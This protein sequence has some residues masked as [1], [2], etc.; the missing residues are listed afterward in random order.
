MQM[1]LIT[2]VL[3]VGLFALLSIMPGNAVEMLITSNPRVRPEDIVRLK[4]LRGLDRPW[5]VQYHRW[6]WGYYDPYRAPHIRVIDPLSIHWNEDQTKVFVDLSASLDNPDYPVNF[7]K[8]FLQLRAERP[9]LADR[10]ENVVKGA[11]ESQK[12]TTFL[13]TIFYEDVDYYNRINRQMRTEASSNLKIEGLFG[14]LVQ[15][16]M[17]Q[18]GIGDDNFH[19]LWFKVTNIH[20]LETISSVQV[21]RPSH[22][23]P[24]SAQIIVDDIPIQIV[25]DPQ[26]FVVNL[27]QYV[28]C[29]GK[30]CQ[31]YTFGLEPGSP[32]I[33]DAQGV[34]KNNFKTPGQSEVRFSI[35]DSR[36]EISRGAFAVEHGYV[37]NK[38]KFNRGFLFIFA[39]DPLALGF[40]NTYK[41]PV[42]ELLA[43]EEPFCEGDVE[44]MAMCS[45]SKVFAQSTSLWGSLSAWTTRTIIHSGR[46]GNTLQL[47]IPSL[48]LSLLIALPLGVLCA[49]RQYSWLDYIV[50]FLAFIGISLPVF[51]LGIMMISVFAESLQWLP[52]GGI[53]SVDI[54]KSSL[55]EVLAN[56]LRHLM[57]PVLALSVAYAGRWLRFMRA[58]M[59]EVLPA[60]YIRTARAKGLGES[61]VIFKHALQN[62]LIPVVTVMA[63]SIPAL[64]GGAVLTETVFAWPGIGRLQYEAVMNSD[65]YVAI[66]IFLISA[67]LVMLGNLLADLLYIIVDPRIRRS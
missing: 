34:Y 57:L 38:E 17:L 43:G 16:T 12:L 44:G 22:S 59:L 21:Q 58:S 36:G 37:M 64:F 39:G 53:Q 33:I 10:V 54:E 32:G 46:I 1:I 47:M 8:L 29:V 50:N 4:K 27:K 66:V 24:T 35:K 3:S 63:I 41:R 20:G 51:W 67:V 25:D 55:E 42:W 2:F 14:S 18:A 48:F 23:S 61:A 11:K 40:S 65:Y 26:N 15:G 28:H 60:D 13:E 9:N 56:R 19:R 62:A 31:K 5:Y 49:Y 45:D 6:M 52:A 30:G 7:E